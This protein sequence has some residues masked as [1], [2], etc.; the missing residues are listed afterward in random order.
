MTAKHYIVNAGNSIIK[1]YGN[2]WISCTLSRV[3]LF[4]ESDIR[5]KSNTVY[6]IRRNGIDIT[7]DI[8]QV[9]LLWEN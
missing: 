6:T 2:S 5:E 4:Q 8:K 3:L 7:V 9:Q 1:H